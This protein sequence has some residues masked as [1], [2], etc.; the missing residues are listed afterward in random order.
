MHLLFKDFFSFKWLNNLNLTPHLIFPFETRAVVACQFLS[1]SN[2]SVREC[3]RLLGLILIHGIH[4]SESIKWA[5][6]LTAWI[7]FNRCT[8]FYRIIGIVSWNTSLRNPCN[9]CIC[10]IWWYYILINHTINIVVTWFYRLILF[11]TFKLYKYLF[12]NMLV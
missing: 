7:L 2:T 1:P 12:L 8:F 9:Y 5:Y 3:V 4:Y 10:I 6:V 11:W